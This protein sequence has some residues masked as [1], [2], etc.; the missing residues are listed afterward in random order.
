MSVKYTVEDNIDFYAELYKSLNEDEANENKDTNNLCLITNQPLS[1]NYVKLPC[2]HS[3]NYVALFKDLVN[4][5]K[6]YLLMESTPLKINQIRCPYCREKHTMLLP[7]YEDV[8]G[9][10]KEHGVNCIDETKIYGVPNTPTSCCFIVSHTSYNGTPLVCNNYGYLLEENNKYYCNYH[11]YKTIKTLQKKAQMEAKAAE[12]KKKAEEK[13]MAKAE[14]KKKKLEAKALAKNMKADAKKKQ[15]PEVIN[16]DDNIILSNAPSGCVQI[17]KSGER[18]G[19]CCG[20]SSIYLENMCM[21]HYKM[22][23]KSEA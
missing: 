10:T 2:G 9:V 13:E 6:K 16:L 11:K 22:T 19:Q 7:L 21:R 12:K 3:F 8:P 5:K 20:A 1:E 14:E 4:Y 15:K 18:K 17:L 23:H